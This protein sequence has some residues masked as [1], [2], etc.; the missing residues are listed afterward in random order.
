MLNSGLL[1]SIKQD[2]ET[3]QDDYDTWNKKYDFT[4]DPCCTLDNCKCPDGLF[5]D[6]EQDGLKEP[7]RGRVFMNPPYIEAKLWIPKAVTEA[8]R[9]GVE[10]VVGLLPARSDTVVFHKY[11]WDRKRGQFR[12]GVEVDFLPGRL[13]FGSDHYWQSIWDAEYV[14]DAKGKKKENPLYMQYGKK[15]GSPFPSMLVHWTNKPS[16]KLKAKSSILKSRE[17][18]IIKCIRMPEDD[19]TK[20]RGILAA[21]MSE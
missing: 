10:F 5:Y 12:E 18:A 20:M 21:E 17:A 15:P 1:S 7:W 4:F 16:P 8:Q 13:R 2:W 11:I 3:P 6:L 14:L 19:G 9:P